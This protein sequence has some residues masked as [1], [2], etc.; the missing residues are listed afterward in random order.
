M[1][2]EDPLDSGALEARVKDRVKELLDD[3]DVWYFMPPASTYGRS[4]IPDFIGC[5]NGSFFAVETKRPK[6]GVLSI[7]QEIEISDIKRTLGK[8]FIVHNID[9]TEYKE[10][11]AW[12]IRKQKTYRSKP[13]PKVLPSRV[14][15]IDV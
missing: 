3:Y 13:A 12:V 15:T 2:N 4:G 14:R 1:S 9:S 8:V 6:G 11:T 7:P 10:L 5:I